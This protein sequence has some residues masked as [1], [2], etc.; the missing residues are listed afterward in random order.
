MF[1]RELTMRLLLLSTLCIVHLQ[2]GTQECP[3]QEI[4]KELVQKIKEES[5]K[6]TNRMIAAIY[7]AINA[8]EDIRGE[9]SI[10]KKY[11]PESTTASLISLGKTVSQSSTGFSG[12]ANLA[13]DGKYS[14]DNRHGTCTHTN[15]EVNPWWQIDL[16]KKYNVQNVKVWNRGDGWGERLTSLIVQT[17]DDGIQWGDAKPLKQQAVTGEAYDIDV[18]SN[19]RFVRLTI[20]KP[21]PEY[22]T[23]CEVEVYGEPVKASLI[24]LGKMA[25]QSST[26]FNGYANLANDGKYSQDYR[27]GTCTHTNSEVK[28]WWQMDLG[29]KY[30]VQFVK[31]W[32][33]GDCCGERLTSLI[34]QTSDDGIQW[35]DAKPLKQQVMTGGIYDIDVHSTGRFV[36]LTIS[37]PAAEYLTL[38]E[39]EV[40]GEPV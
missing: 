4:S 28:P 25:S 12:P 3:S 8:I 19:G 37:K 7:K 11:I 36:R 33:R 21:A 15:S 30:N 18:N 5:I 6:Q 22:L 10:L 34:V 17:S 1:A 9:I 20:S 38:C 2:A 24:S 14:Q 31:V 29:K 32:N 23:L 27:H 26:D 40:Y 13:N 39:V 35:G 16:G